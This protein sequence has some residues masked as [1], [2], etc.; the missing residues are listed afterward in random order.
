MVRKAYTTRWL[1]AFLVVMAGATGFAA[2]NE[3]ITADFAPFLNGKPWPRFKID[4]YVE[5]ESKVWVH[6]LASHR[7]PTVT[8]IHHQPD[9]TTTVIQLPDGRRFETVNKFT[10]EFMVWPFL[11]AVYCGDFNGDGKPDFVAIKPGSG[12]GL[13]AENCTGIF[14]FS[15]G[16]GYRFT[17]ISTMG[18]GPHDLVLDPETK[19]FRLIQT[20]F[21]QAQ[22]SDGKTHSFWVHRFF[23]LGNS[24]R[25]ERDD[26]LP[27]VWIQYLNRHNHEATKLLTKPLK[28]KAWAIDSES[29]PKIDL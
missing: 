1:W 29:E 9:S 12:C 14:A 10:N 13:A 11:S 21:R 25:F 26:S 4:T 23:K 16:N 19:S 3:T 18:L 22:C 24:L 15:D 5:T 7:F 2:T 6:P 17:R 28:A 27:T 20:S 8:E